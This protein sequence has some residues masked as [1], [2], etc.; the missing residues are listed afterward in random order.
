[1]NFLLFHNNYIKISS[2]NI[3]KYIALDLVGNKSPVYSQTYTINKITPKIVKPNPE[4]CAINI[5]LTKPLTIT[6]NENIL[7]GI[8]YNNIYVKNLNTGK[9]VH[10]YPNQYPKIH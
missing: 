9:P 8:N 5:P 2:S 1:M 6:F 10:I 7:K 4:Y 3:L